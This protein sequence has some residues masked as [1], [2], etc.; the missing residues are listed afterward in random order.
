[1]KSHLSRKH[2][3]QT[4][5]HL[6]SRFI[7]E[8]LEEEAEE[9]PGEA[10]LERVL[11]TSCGEETIEDDIYEEKEDLAVLEGIDETLDTSDDEEEIFIKAVAIMVI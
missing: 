11:E 8:M 2:P 10:V 3:V 6:D 9:G 1:M 4:V 7:V 5:T